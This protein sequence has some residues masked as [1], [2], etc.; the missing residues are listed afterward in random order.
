MQLLETWTWIY[1]KAEICIQNMATILQYVTNVK[2]LWILAS[3]LTIVYTLNDILE[4]VIKNHLMVPKDAPQKKGWATMNSFHFVHL[5]V[6]NLWAS[7]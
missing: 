7:L 3:A 2:A 5:K 4:L 1:A 6:I